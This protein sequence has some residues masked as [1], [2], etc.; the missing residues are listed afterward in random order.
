MLIIFTFM[1]IFIFMRGSTCIVYG[2]V[3]KWRWNKEALYSAAYMEVWKQTTTCISTPFGIKTGE[4]CK[5]ED[6]PLTL[7]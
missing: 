5:K 7:Q 4:T 2:D 3:V 6:G 1:I